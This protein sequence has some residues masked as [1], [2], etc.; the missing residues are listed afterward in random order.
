[1]IFVMDAFLGGFLLGDDVVNGRLAA[2]ENIRLKDY[3]YYSA[4]YYF[5]TICTKNKQNLL[6]YVGMTVLGRPHIELT[7]QRK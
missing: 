5:I 4:G 1:M 2:R 3:D 6:G 7:P